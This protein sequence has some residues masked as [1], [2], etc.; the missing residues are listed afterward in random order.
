MNNNYYYNSNKLLRRRIEVF[1]GGF[2]QFSAYFGHPMYFGLP[3]N[4]NGPWTKRTTDK[5]DHGGDKMDVVLGQKGPRFGQNGP[6]MGH[7]S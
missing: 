4:R 1:F 3:S 7:T 6:C 2:R 5:T